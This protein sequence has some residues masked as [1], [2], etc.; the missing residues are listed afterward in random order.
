M[1]QNFSLH[2]PIPFAPSWS[3]LTKDE[4]I[5]RLSPCSVPEL[6]TALKNLGCSAPVLKPVLLQDL[7]YV[8]LSHIPRVFNLSLT[9]LRSLCLNLSNVDDSLPLH[10]LPREALISFLLDSSLGPVVFRSLRRIPP[11]ASTSSVHPALA[12]LFHLPEN[13]MREALFS[14]DIDFMRDILHFAHPLRNFSQLGRKNHVVSLFLQYYLTRRQEVCSSSTSELCIDL[15]SLLPASNKPIADTPILQLSVLSAEFTDHVVALLTP[16][17]LPNNDSS[18]PK[19]IPEHVKLACLYNYWSNSLWVPPSPCSVCDRAIHG[20]KMHHLNSLSQQFQLLPWHILKCHDSFLTSRLHLHY[21]VPLIA[22]CLLSPKGIHQIDGNTI[23]DICADCLGPLSN[24]RVPRFALANNLFRGTLPPEFDDLNW[25]EERVCALAITTAII[26]RIYGSSDPR[27]PRYFRGNTCAH[28]M[29]VSS[30]ATVLPRTPADINDHISVVFLGSAPF[31]DACLKSVF[32]IRKQKVWALLLW[33]KRNNILYKDITLSESILDLYPDQDMLPGVNDRVIQSNTGIEHILFEDESAGYTDHPSL[34]ITDSVSTDNSTTILIDKLGAVDPDGACIPG[35]ALSASAIKNLIPRNRTIP[36]LMISNSQSAIPEYDNPALFP[37]MFPT[38]FPYG[39]GGF[40]DSTRPNPISFLSHANSLLDCSDRKPRYHWSY[41]FTALNI[42]QRRTAHLQTHLTVNRPDFDRISSQLSSVSAQTL[43]KLSE[44]IRD[45]GNVGD[46]SNEE[47]AALTLLRE[48]NT[49]STKIPGSQGSMLKT[50]S[51]FLGQ[52]AVHG[53]PPF[54]YTMNPCAQHSPLFQLMYGDTS[55]DLTSRYPNLVPGPERATRLA[56]D[57]V[58]A[59]DFFQFCFERTFEDLFGWDFTLRRSKPDGGLL[60][61][62]SSFGGTIEVTGRGALHGHFLINVSGSFNPTE[63]HTLLKGNPEY[64]KQYFDFFEDTVQHHLPSVVLDPEFEKTHDPRTER[65]PRPPNPALMETDPVRYD[66]HLKVF[67]KEMSDAEIK[68][69]GERMQR[70]ECQKVCHKYGHEHTCRFNFPHELVEKSW[71]DEE[72]NAVVFLVKDATVNFHNRY[73]LVFC[74][75]NHDLKCILSGRAARAAVIYITDYITKM[76]MRTYQV[77]SLLSKA[78]LE[79]DSATLSSETYERSSK[80]LLHKCLTQLSRKREIHAQMAVRFL[81]GFRDSI[82]SHPSAPMLSGLLMSHISRTYSNVQQDNEPDHSLSGSHDNDDDHS[83]VPT[84]F[85]DSEPEQLTLSVDE[86]GRLFHVDQVIDYLHRD[87]SLSHICFFMFVHAFKKEKKNKTV[88]NATSESN[89]ITTSIVPEL[90]AGSKPRFHL[91]SPHPQSRTHDL[92]LC[93]SLDH[94]PRTWSRIPRMIGSTIPRKTDTPRYYW[95]VLAHFKPFSISNPLVPCDLPFSIDS[96]FESYQLS[97]LALRVTNNWEELCNCEDERD[98]ERLRKASQLSKESHLLAK[99]DLYGLNDSADLPLVEAT[100]SETQFKEDIKNMEDLEHFR[101][102]G[103]FKHI[104]RITSNA[105]DKTSYELDPSLIVAIERDLPRL[106]K[107]WETQLK[108]T[109]EAVASRRRNNSAIHSQTQTDTIRD[110]VPGTLHSNAFINSEQ[111]SLPAR[112]TISTSSISSLSSPLT[113][114]QII[115]NVGLQNSLNHEQWIAYRIIA[116]TFLEHRAHDLNPASAPKPTP[117]RMFLTGP[118]GTGK[119]HVVNAVKQV[120]KHYGCEDRIR[121]LAPTGSA[122][123][124]IDG[125]TIHTGLNIVIKNK[126]ADSTSKP[127]IEL[128]VKNKIQVRKEWG[129]VYI[130]FID[131]ISMVGLYLLAQIESALRYGKERFDEFFGGIIVVFSGDLYQFPPVKDRAVYSDIK[132]RGSVSDTELMIRLGKLAWNSITDVVE[133][134]HQHRMHRDP[135]YGEAVKRLRT[136][137]CTQADADLF[138]SRVMKG[139]DNPGGVDMSNPE[140]SSSIAVV[141]TNSLRQALNVR[142]ALSLTSTKANQDSLEFEAFDEIGPSRK[143]LPDQDGHLRPR[144]QLLRTIFKSAKGNSRKIPPGYLH[145]YVGMPVILKDKNISTDLRLTNGAC[146]TVAHLSA[147]NDG[148]RRILDKVFIHFPDSPLELAHLPKGVVPISPVTSTFH[149]SL[150]CSDGNKKDVLVRRSQCPVQGG[151]AVTAHFVQG[152]TIPHSISSLRKG[153]AHAYVCAS[154]P[155]TRFG[156]VLT[157]R[158]SLS[159]LNRARQSNLTR[160]SQRLRVIEHNTLVKYG[161][162]LEP[163]KP[164]IPCFSSESAKVVYSESNNENTYNEP[165]AKRGQKRRKPSNT[166]NVSFLT[167]ELNLNVCATTPLKRSRFSNTLSDPSTLQGVQWSDDWSCAYDSVIMS[168][169]AAFSPSPDFYVSQ[170]AQINNFTA[171]LTPSLTI[172]LH[173]P[174]TLNFNSCRDHLRDIL[175]NADSLAFPRH[176]SN[177]ITVT[178]ILEK[179]SNR[180]ILCPFIHLSITCSTCGDLAPPTQTQSCVLKTLLYPAQTSPSPVSNLY[181]VSPWICHAS[182]SSHS[183]TRLLTTHSQQCSIPPCVKISLLSP[184]LFLFF[185]VQG[186]Q[187]HRIA[188]CTFLHFLT[189]SGPC[190]YKL[191]SVIY[192]G[193]CHFVTHF[194]A[195]RKSWFHDGRQNS[196]DCVLIGNEL[197]SS[198]FL[199]PPIH[200]SKTTPNI[201]LFVKCF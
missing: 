56:H 121:F 83:P 143:P 132:D 41:V 189:P 70:H 68:R 153:G 63:L 24:K 119:T 168:F 4:L 177:P 87:S 160:E 38:L 156:I 69:C 88:S 187:S 66:E 44:K 164:L 42:H 130:V 99:A 54:Y 23:L 115:E 73:L 190:K 13:V 95:F 65:P 150:P 59:A 163:L 179:L 32:F 197:S 5:I 131:E 31:K 14:L 37:S 16:S 144:D 170:F 120:M 50:R 175:F 62:I 84:T 6:R 93:G 57:P 200:L 11:R 188:A 55:V 112:P 71:Y 157:E 74:R 111:S 45:E 192:H 20:S 148:S 176:G 198:Q 12:P 30:T 64:Q 48:V 80:S 106:S 90:R 151:F 140:N 51:E 126:S 26:A 123:T 17:K 180:S 166:D 195:H 76:D 129:S 33:L 22:G 102:A 85:A 21:S 89:A 117:L 49:I 100:D 114:Q 145:L 46:L 58:A 96:F 25:V 104:P 178:S 138:N 43:L 124:L 149:Y 137:Q 158:V 91:L 97:D 72:H 122:A 125:T 67:Y 128:S 147:R 199:S 183:H 196:G 2:A 186:L 19:I 47:K 3:N 155:T 61:H 118:G 77:L 110:T 136:A 184:P 34:P 152:K 86:S 103:Y 201:F 113:P 116:N 162:K 133:L 27:N 28:E 167:T 173:E 146:G 15:Q 171:K 7:A 141:A 10:S 9:T 185:E 82:L 98:A 29:N 18:W 142:K 169:Y 81:R 174:S 109:A 107:A 193:N 127:L 139:I 161:F 52:I 191:C 172:L 101:A 60:G 181:E 36:D 1:E 154:R 8:L 105:E 40:D 159:H 134:H 108:A 78:V 39:V 75:H 53:L 182:A 35:R 94:D 135:E 92:V 165:S 194:L 79:C